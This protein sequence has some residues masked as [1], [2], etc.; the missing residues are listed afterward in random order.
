M[1]DDFQEALPI[2]GAAVI[3]AAD[4]ALT[5]GFSGLGYWAIAGVI[6]ADVAVGASI[7]YATQAFITGSQKT[8]TFNPTGIG[9]SGSAGPR[10]MSPGGKSFA[11]TGDGGFRITNTSPQSPVP[12]IIGTYMVPGTLLA[13]FPLGENNKR[14]FYVVGIA[15][16]D[17]SKVNVLVDNTNISTLPNYLD[18]DGGDDPDDNKPWLEFFGS[19]GSSG[20]IVLA[21]SG[22]KFYDL[23]AAAGETVNAPFVKF[24]T[25][26]SGR[27]EAR[28]F[29]SATIPGIYIDFIE[30]EDADY[31]ALNGKTLIIAYML[32]TDITAVTTETVTFTGA[33]ID[34]ASTVIEI[35]AQTTAITATVSAVD[36]ITIQSNNGNNR[37]L[38]ITG[39]AQ[40]QLTLS[41]QNFGS[42]ISYV[43]SRQEK[44]STTVT[45][46]FS[47]T[48]FSLSKLENGLPV[49]I[50]MLVKVTQFGGDW[51]ED[52][53]LPNDGFWS[54]ILDVTQ[55]TNGGTVNIAAVEVMSDFVKSENGDFSGI[56]NQTLEMDVNKIPRDMTFGGGTNTL[57]QAI[58]DI[59]TQLGTKVIASNE[60][61]ELLIESIAS[62]VGTDTVTEIKE[63]KITGGTSAAAINL[64]PLYSEAQNYNYSGIGYAIIN[65][66][67]N[68]QISQN[69]QFTFEVSGASTNPAQNL[70]DIFE[71]K[72]VFGK[73]INIPKEINRNSF[74]NSIDFDT[75]ESFF[76]NMGILDSSYGEVV[77]ALVD[78]GS[79]ILFESGGIYKLIPETNSQSAAEL[80]VTDDFKKDGIIRDSWSLSTIDNTLKFNVLRVTYPDS[81]EDY[82]S[83][84]IVIDVTGEVD[85]ENNEVPRIYENNQ[86]INISDSQLDFLR[87]STRNFPAVTSRAQALRLGNQ[88]FKKQNLGNLSISFA[89]SIRHT[90]LEKGDIVDLFIDELG[91]VGKSFRILSIQE[92]NDFGY[93]LI[94]SE[95]FSEMYQ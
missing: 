13:N 61:D 71:G 1:G 44:D 75:T 89:V 50:T 66:V 33:A 78:A 29:L 6:A 80:H 32:S 55:A 5:G 16:S 90:F 93:R 9:G 91:F 59:N 37:R 85:T 68:V 82:I 7:G 56:A 41:T 65:L 86:L 45:T 49:P 18:V 47:D 46:L 39:T 94:C 25:V 57:A 34:A 20:D 19:G 81:D 30:S 76:C 62:P 2:I 27:D 51:F 14:S 52:I 21:N 31:T 79:L 92:T 60:D 40:V 23:K 48:N 12:I 22:K 53:S 36:E 87:A 38:Q 43:V 70:L 24:F 73:G 26:V 72:G 4:I 54:F 63:I 3:L 88:I 64:K 28:I 10:G 74:L 77:Q 95:H 58:S 42:V 67:R 83:R 11:S 8:P 84:D 17:I 35:N 69:P 15:K